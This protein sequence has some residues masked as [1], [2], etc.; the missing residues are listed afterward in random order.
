MGWQAGSKAGRQAGKKAGGQ[1]SRKG[2]RRAE[3]SKKTAK[4]VFNMVIFKENR[5]ILL[6]QYCVS[7]NQSINEIGSAYTEYISRIRLSLF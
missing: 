6:I 4:N 3:D 1:E 2:C 5:P 7:A